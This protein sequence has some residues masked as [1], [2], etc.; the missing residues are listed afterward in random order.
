ME[1]KQISIL[2]MTNLPKKYSSYRVMLIVLVAILCCPSYASAAFNGVSDY[3]DLGRVSSSITTNGTF[4]AWIKAKTLKSAGIIEAESCGGN[5]I[6][7]EASGKI[8]SNIWE[9]WTGNPNSLISS[10]T[11]ITAGKWYHIARTWTPTTHKIYIDGR[12]VVSVAKDAKAINSGGL[13]VYIGNRRIY[14][15]GLRQFF[16]GQIDQVRVWNVARSQVQIQAD[17]KR[18]VVGNEAGLLAYWPEDAGKIILKDIPP[19]AKVT[20]LLFVR[21]S[22]NGDDEIK[23]ISYGKPFYIKAEFDSPP[24]E[25]KKTVTLDWGEGTGKKIIVKQQ[26]DNKEIFLSDIIY[27]K[28]PTSSK[29]GE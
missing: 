3:V 27:V 1:W 12:V 29:E 9:C 8:Y 26:T 24:E 23:E 7:I 20:K 6:G 21:K 13:R 4:E 18:Q 5:S 17:M 10:K 22:D 11:T 28:R 19:D 2:R 14:G 16:H 15:S 25:K